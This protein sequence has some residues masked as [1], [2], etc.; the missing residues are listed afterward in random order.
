M[1]PLCR[2]STATTAAFKICLGKYIR[3]LNIHT[4]PSNLFLWV[5]F[6]I[7][8]SE[9]TSIF[10]CLYCLPLVLFGSCGLC[11]SCSIQTEHTGCNR[12]SS[13]PISSSVMYFKLLIMLVN[14]AIGLQLAGICLRMQPQTSHGDTL[15]LSRH[16]TERSSQ[17]ISVGLYMHTKTHLWK[18]PSHPTENTTAQWPLWPWGDVYPG[19]NRNVSWTSSVMVAMQR[20]WE[21]LNITFASWTYTSPGVQTCSVQWCCQSWPMPLEDLCLIPWNVMAMGGSSWWLMLSLRWARNIWGSRG[22]P[23]SPREDDG[24]NPAGVILHML[25]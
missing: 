9:L 2:A 12:L 21:L 25:G 10:C 18:K 15:L 1:H 8:L 7:Q 19:G 3:L 23:W 20:K 16:C 24:T 6:G 11:N 22:R 14:L 17:I 5:T 4:V 13:L